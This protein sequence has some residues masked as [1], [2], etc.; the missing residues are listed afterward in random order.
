[1]IA[2]NRCNKEIDINET[3]IEV[4]QSIQTELDYTEIQEVDC[5]FCLDCWKEMM[6]FLHSEGQIGTSF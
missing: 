4:L 5:R 2:C 1:M 3:L 6:F